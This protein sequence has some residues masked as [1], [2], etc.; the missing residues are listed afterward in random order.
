MLARKAA[1]LAAFVMIVSAQ[2]CPSGAVPTVMASPV[3]FRAQG[4][5]GETQAQVRVEIGEGHSSPLW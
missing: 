5:A 4:V 3:P 1:G 2:E